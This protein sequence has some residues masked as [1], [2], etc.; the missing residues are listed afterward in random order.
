MLTIA[1]KQKIKTKYGPWAL[2]T[3]ASSGIGLELAIQLA[4]AGFNLILC[5]RNVQRLQN[6]ESQV[7]GRYNVETKLVAADMSDQIAIDHLIQ[8]VQNLDI[9]L[10][11]LSAGYGTSGLFKDVS[12]HTEINMLRVNCESVLSLTHYFT[13]RFLSRGKG[14]I[15]L[16]SSIVAF[17]GVPYAA[18]YAATKAYIQSLGEALAVELKP[19]GID[20]L[21]AAPGPVLTGFGDRAN[22]TM[23]RSLRPSDISVPILRALGK[24]NTVLPGTLTRILMFG[25]GMVPRRKKVLIM[26]KVMAGMANP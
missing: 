20:V 19:L 5:A 16:L 11:I 23:G 24:K 13:Q 6:A 22:M 10:V 26:K 15:I 17:Q 8:S 14:G 12:L 1:E 9:G 4:S 3:G 2:V 25:L 7:R 21:S 18:H